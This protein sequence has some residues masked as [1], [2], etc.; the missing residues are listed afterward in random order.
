MN[1]APHPSTDAFSAETFL[2]SFGA[3]IAATTTETKPSAMLTMKTRRQ[4]LLSAMKPAR[5]GATM[6]AM[7]MTEPYSPVYFARSFVGNR[8][9]NMPTP[10]VN[11][12]ALPMP[13]RIRAMNRTIMEGATI[14]MICWMVSITAP[15]TM[16]LLFVKSSPAL[17]MRGV[18]TTCAMVPIVNIRLKRA[19]PFKASASGT[20]IVFMANVRYICAKIAM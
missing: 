2:S 18:S 13:P 9:A 11:R 14:T 15:T 19:M 5:V 4:L 10:M 7:A 6:P 3:E 17:P 16:H 1:S 12:I 20:A 8:S